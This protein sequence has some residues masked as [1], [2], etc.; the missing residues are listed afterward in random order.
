MPTIQAVIFDLDGTLLDTLDDLA[1]S[2]NRVLSR[3]GYPTHP[4]EA[5]KYFVGDGIEKLAFRVLP[6]KERDEQTISTC[7]NALREDYG[8][9][10]K[11]QTR[12]YD[13]IEDM[14]SGLSRLGIK[15]AILSNKPHH[16]TEITV[17]HYFANWSFNEVAGAVAG[18][19]KKP[20]PAGAI[21]IIDKMKIAA[22]NFLYLG[23]TS[24]DMKTAK[25]AGVLA[26][27][28]L[29]GFRTETELIESGAKAVISNPAEI[30]NHLK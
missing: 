5:Y 28:A 11:D 18:I 8:R 24:T 21:Q 7:V 15:L 17:S 16:L 13:G 12:L 2:T 4:T 9:H 30:F 6:P 25:G 20:D 27:G 29:W 26:I 22:E 10:W 19:P 3:H 14:L 1:D 23:D